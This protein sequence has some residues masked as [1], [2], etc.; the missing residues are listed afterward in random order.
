M[1]LF[2]IVATKNHR[3]Q[4]FPRRLLDPRR[5][6]RKPTA[7]ELEEFLVEY[8]PVLPN[9]PRR[10]LSHNYDVSP[11]TIVFIDIIQTV[12]SGRQYSTNRHRTSPAGINLS[13]TRIWVGYIPYPGRPFKH[14]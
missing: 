4:S 7:E 12:S 11:S 9:D 2:F 10:V 14:I 8:D 6:H 1:I 5:P 13:G 3:I